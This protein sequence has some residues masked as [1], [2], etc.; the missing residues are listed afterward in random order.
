MLKYLKITLCHA[1]LLEHPN[2]EL[3]VGTVVEQKAWKCLE[4]VI[5]PVSIQKTLYLVLARLGN[6]SNYSLKCCEPGM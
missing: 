5:N 6:I 3:D 2:I 4:T 1:T